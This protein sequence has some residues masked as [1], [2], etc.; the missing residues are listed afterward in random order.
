[1][2]SIF[3][4]RV[5]HWLRVMKEKGHSPRFDEDGDLDIFALEADPHNGPG[6]SVC[7]GMWCWNCEQPEEIEACDVLDLVANPQEPLK[8]ETRK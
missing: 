1:M 2:K 3:P 4:E 5:E 8:L 7:G 6:C